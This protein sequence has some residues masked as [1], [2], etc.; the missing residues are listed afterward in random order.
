[1][2][3]V[4]VYCGA[5]LGRP[6]A[7]AAAA[8]A[9]GGLLARRGLG[10]VFGGGGVGLM[11]VLANAALAGGTEVIGV[12][13]RALMTAELAHPHV[14]DLRV[15][16]SMH[17]RKALMADL[18]D[19]FIALPGGYGTLDETFEILTWLQLGFHSKPFGLLN[20]E[21]Y[22]DHLLHFLDRGIADELLRREHRAE[23]LV[24]TDPAPLLDRLSVHRPR[25]C[26]KWISA[27]AP[28]R[29]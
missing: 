17:H 22:F 11:G 14:A 23:I 25:P 1:M 12:L 16:E 27:A 18:A 24:E 26:S 28:T 10:L 4:A 15:V 5:S 8:T 7:F 2:K 3:R 29:P 13:P 6:P 20:V 19:A 21:G 9:L